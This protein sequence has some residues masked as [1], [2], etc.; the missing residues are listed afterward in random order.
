C[1]QWIQNTRREDLIGNNPQKLNSSGYVL[2]SKHFEPSQFL[3]SDQ[4]RKRLVW[5]AVP[6]VFDVPNPPPK[7]KSRKRSPRKRVAEPPK[8]RQRHYETDDQQTSDSSDMTSEATSQP[9]CEEILSEAPS[10]SSGLSDRE[11]TRKSRLKVSRNKLY[12]AI[13][14]LQ[15]LWKDLHENFGFRFLLT[16]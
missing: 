7:L 1:R 2:C 11:K 10:T 12:R 15:A 4:P 6:T 8:K 3:C 13:T 14:A 16:D 9:H 5:N